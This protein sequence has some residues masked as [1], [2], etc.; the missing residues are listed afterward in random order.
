V[1]H[2]AIASALHDIGKAKIPL[3]I[4]DKPGALT[5]AEF[6]HIK[7]H[8]QHGYDMVSASGDYD[9]A[10]LHAVLHHHE[11]LDGTGYPHGLSAAAIPD[12][13][14]IITIVDIFAA[15]VEERVYRAAMP[16]EKAFS[17]LDDM[18]GKLDKSL[19]NA[20][21]PV[22]LASSSGSEAALQPARV[23]ALRR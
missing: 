9:E 16:F 13:T 14:R 5:P 4:L 10:V 6:A 11:Y 8:P 15:L 17:I 18:T 3:E 20:F 19:V 7:L 2:I 1:L 22:A 21:R 23:A 12:L